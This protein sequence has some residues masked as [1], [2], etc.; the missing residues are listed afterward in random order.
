MAVLILLPLRLC[1]C[2]FRAG[3]LHLYGLAQD[4]Y[5]T[6]GAAGVHGPLRLLVGLVLHKGKPRR[7]VKSHADTAILK[8]H[9]AIHGLLG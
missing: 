1:R 8:L 9:E 5:R 2:R 4:L 3:H 6:L 7:L